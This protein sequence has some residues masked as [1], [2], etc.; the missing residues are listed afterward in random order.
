MGGVDG[1]LVIG[2]FLVVLNL[3]NT[4]LAPIKKMP[5]VGRLGTLLE[6][7]SGTGKVR[8]LI[9]EGDVALLSPHPP[10]EFPDGRIDRLHFLRPLIGYGPESM[11]VAYNRF[12]PPDLAHV[13]ARNASTITP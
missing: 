6:T 1:H 7:G 12:Y 8:I 9:W 11:W 13:E 4:P 3:P 5:Y 2:A 10:L